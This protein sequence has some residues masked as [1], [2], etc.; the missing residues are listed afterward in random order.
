MKKNPKIFLIDDDEDDRN[1]FID[2]INEIDRRIDCVCFSNAVE[3][4]KKLKND[5][6]NI[7]DFIF[8]DLN[9]PRIEGKQCLVEIKSI[10]Q[11]QYTP[12][13]IYSTS[14]IEE[15]IKDT[16]KLGAS[17]FLTKPA[18][19]KDLKYALAF[20]IASGKEL[21]TSILK[22]LVSVF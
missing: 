21:K 20:I 19:F 11:L 3:A 14:Q 10:K 8:L 22:E 7:P 18:H 15:E 13:I 16:Q 2:A 1:F 9:M 6:N 5:T 12:V 17:Y 4:L